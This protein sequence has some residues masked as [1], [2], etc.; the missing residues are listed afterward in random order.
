MSA[1]AP[2]DV[3]TLVLRLVTEVPRGWA[4]LGMALLFAVCASGAS[5]ALMGVSAWLLSFAA[6]HP[7]V[8][9]L[10]LAA[11]GVR[12]FGT[13]RGVFRYFERIFSHDVALRMQAALRLSTYTKLA[14]TTLLGTRSGDMLLRVTADV[15]AIMDVVVRVALPFSSAVV[16]ILGTSLMMTLFSPLSA[17]VLLGCSVLAGI[18]LPFVTQVFS[19]RADESIAPARAD[20]ANQV[21]TLAHNATDLVAYGYGDTELARLDAVDARLREAERRAAFTRGLAAGG[22]LVVMGMA[23]AAALVIGADAVVSGALAGRNLAV[24]CLTPLALHESFGDL[25]KAAQTLTQARTSLTRILT[26]L[27]VEP[28]GIGDRVVEQP[29]KRSP[30]QHPDALGVCLDVPLAAQ[31]ESPSS[32][33]SDILALVLTHLTIGW[34]GCPDLLHGIN[35]SVNQGERVVITGA[36]GIGKT[37]LAAT[38]LGLVPPVD[39]CVHAPGH[40]AYL[41]QDA[42]IFATTVAENVRIGN[43]Q[44]TDDEIATALTK[45]GAAHLEP[46]RIVGEDGTTLSGGEARRLALARIFVS[47]DVPAVVILDEPTEHLDQETATSLMEDVYTSFAQS[48]LLIITHDPDVIA[49]SERELHLG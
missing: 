18:V 8:S 19:R 43:P 6:E 40:I 44:A 20:M 33:L 12:T 24:L 2:K 34:P 27:A 41:A 45:A 5:V 35:L 16:V 17:A 22:Q 1:T 36:S 9:M 3:R 25:T 14:R 42:H 30:L 38:I 39:G 48:A 26:L 46:Q 28:V 49:Q 10:T 11:T 7:A 47:A 31:A 37:T 21:F 15:E 32:M 4:R 29:D 23:V 13:S